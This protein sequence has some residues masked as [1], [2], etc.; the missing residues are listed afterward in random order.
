MSPPCARAAPPRPCNDPPPVDC[1]IPGRSHTPATG[2]NAPREMYGLR[3]TPGI[4]CAKLTPKGN[5]SPPVGTGPRGYRRW[6]WLRVWGPA[7]ERGL[8]GAVAGAACCLSATVRTA[9]SV[10]ELRVEV[11]AAMGAYVY[12]ARFLGRESAGSHTGDAMPLRTW[13]GYPFPRSLM[14]WAI[15]Y[16]R[17]WLLLLKAQVVG[18]NKA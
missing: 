8:P 7:G 6:G 9:G 4:V 3:K 5:P 2:G 17:R 18:M 14:R 15:E 1:L 11:H 12:V 16:P 13:R 10:T